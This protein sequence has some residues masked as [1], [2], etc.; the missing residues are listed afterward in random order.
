VEAQR[1]AG[2]V[3]DASTRLPVADAT[4]TLLDSDARELGSGRSD[5]AGVFTILA[6]VPASYLVTVRRL[7]YHGFNSREIMLGHRDTTLVVAL[8]PSPQRLPA[9]V[10]RASRGFF[11][12]EWGRDGF[13]KRRELGTGVFLTRTDVLLKEPQSVEDMLRN[14]D[15]VMVRNQ[16]IGQQ[17]WAYR[18]RGCLR[19][20]LNR[21]PYRSTA[22]QQLLPEDVLGVEIYREFKEVPEELR[23]DS[24]GCGLI[25]MW[26][27]AAW[28]P[29]PPKVPTARDS[30]P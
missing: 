23:L 29:R 20:L 26:T 22:H 27:R 8:T 25:L 30:S 18:G 5:S 4:V 28:A 24:E 6:P 11:A 9:S 3:L 1:A 21:L 13:M 7:G 12:R 19:T 14:V 16:G 15:G 17:V 10:T 2:I